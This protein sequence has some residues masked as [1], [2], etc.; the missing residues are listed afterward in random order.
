M[1]NESGSNLIQR[2]KTISSGCFLVGPSVILSG[3]TVGDKVLI[4]P[5]SVV[6]QDASSRS[7]VD[8]N[9]IQENLFTEERIERLAKRQM[10]HVVS[11]GN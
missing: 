11:A 9:S 1:S 2:K 4:R 3:V 10:R 8:K 6:D 5:F 7:V